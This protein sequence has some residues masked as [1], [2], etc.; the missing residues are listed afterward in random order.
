MATNKTDPM[1]TQI[2]GFVEEGIKREARK[3]A[4]GYKEQI[5][6]DID[7]AMSDIVTKLSTRILKYYSMH[8]AGDHIEIHVRKDL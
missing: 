5:A 1:V 4:D 8:D 3:I 2:Q 7:E 6:K